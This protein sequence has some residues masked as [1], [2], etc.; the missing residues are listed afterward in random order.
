MDKVEEDSELEDYTVRL[1]DG[2]RILIEWNIATQTREIFGLTESDLS[3]D[4]DQDE[5]NQIYK[6]QIFNVLK[7]SMYD[8][9]EE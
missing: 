9:F 1:R 8:L 4:E 7:E 2:V 5:K 6:K 3:E